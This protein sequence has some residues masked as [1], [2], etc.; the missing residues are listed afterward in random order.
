MSICRDALDVS[1]GGVEAVINVDTSGVC[2][3]TEDSAIAL[4]YSTLNPYIAVIFYHRRVNGV[5]RSL[6]AFNFVAKG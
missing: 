4:R 1:D 2:S 6:K 5:C 3:G